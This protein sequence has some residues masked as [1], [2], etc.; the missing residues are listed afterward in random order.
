MLQ[1]I[2]DR[3]PDNAVVI[4]PGDSPSRI[5]TL[6]KLLYDKR[7][8]N[9]FMTSKSNKQKKHIRFVE[10]P[11][12]QL[13]AFDHEEVETERTI[14]HHNHHVI[15]AYIK[16]K[17]PWNVGANIYLLD[18]IFGHKSFRVFEK[19]FPTIR[20]IQSL[21]GCSD[22]SV[23]PGTLSNAETIRARCVPEYNPL[24]PST[25]PIGSLTNIIV[26]FQI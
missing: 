20:T 26:L 6:F 22:R 10:F 1:H 24:S 9:W 11:I 21:L 13:M 16:S 15:K 2:L 4:A 23:I 25:N 3:L 14:E 7:S 17:V 5:V 8:E 12:S 19:I 18:Y